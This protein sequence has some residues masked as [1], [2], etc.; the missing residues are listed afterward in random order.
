MKL[1]EKNKDALKERLTVIFYS[2]QCIEIS[3]NGDVEPFNQLV[4]GEI[5]FREGQFNTERLEK[6]LKEVTK[7]YNGMKNASF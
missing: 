6:R 4:R 1:A 3:F 7:K 5:R 2:S